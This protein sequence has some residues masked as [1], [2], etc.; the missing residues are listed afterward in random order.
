MTENWPKIMREKWTFFSV[1]KVM[2]SKLLV[3]SHL[4]SCVR[5][6]G[7]AW[8]DTDVT[9]LDSTRQRSSS[10]SKPKYSDKFEQKKEWFFIEATA[11]VRVQKVPPGNKHSLPSSRCSKTGQ[12]WPEI[13]V[14]SPFW[15]VKSTGFS[16]T[17]I[18]V[19]ITFPWRVKVGGPL[20]AQ[21]GPKNCP[22]P[23][24]IAPNEPKGDESGVFGNEPKLCFGWSLLLRFGHLQG[25]TVQRGPKLDPKGPKLPKFRIWF[26]LV[27]FW[28][29]KLNFFEIFSK[30]LG[31]FQKLSIWPRIAQMGPKLPKMCPKGTNPNFVPIWRVLSQLLNFLGQN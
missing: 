12:N 21:K 16:L 9:Q 14:F 2:S 25:P 23:T 19:E 4:S 28:A 29:K 24:K 6:C 26:H 15:P 17:K 22:N 18:S 10:L 11:K 20:S 30:F 1:A 31:N 27:A 3:A 8:V 7:A 5:L 13:R